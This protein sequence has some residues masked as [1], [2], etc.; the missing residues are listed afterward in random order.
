[1]IIPVK[2]SSNSMIF[3]FSKSTKLL[4]CFLIHYLTNSVD[5]W[6]SL[7]MN[8]IFCYTWHIHILLYLFSF[9]TVSHCSSLLVTSAPFCHFVLVI[10]CSDLFTT[11]RLSNIRWTQSVNQKVLHPCN[12]LKIWS[13]ILKTCSLSSN[14]WKMVPLKEENVWLK[15]LQ[16]ARRCLRLSLK[17]WRGLKIRKNSSGDVMICLWRQWMW[18]ECW[19]KTRLSSVCCAFI[20]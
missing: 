1:M 3:I 17:F 4:S 12:C 8:S 14:F 18:R 20:V 5:C 9:F 15:R 6:F 10:F 19:M 16:T 2:Y 13:Y 7:P 11:L